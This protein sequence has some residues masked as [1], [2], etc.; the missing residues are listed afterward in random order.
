MKINYSLFTKIISFALLFIFAT[1]K[2]V[3]SEI[4]KKIEVFGND[5][6]AKKTVILFSELNVNDNIYSNDLN[7]AFKKLFDTD[8]FKDVKISFINGNLKIDVIENPLIQSVII[9]GIKN[10]NILYELTKITKKIEKYPY[11]ENKISNQK[12]L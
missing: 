9:N 12:I 8:Y 3:F 7:N 2:L 10:K 5:R 11:L 1:T 6:L 4:I